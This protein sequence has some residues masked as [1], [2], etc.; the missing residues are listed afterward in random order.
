MQPIQFT[1]IIVSLLLIGCTSVELNEKTVPQSKQSEL[2]TLVSV[3][4]IT[5]TN[6]ASKAEADDQ[7][8]ICY[9]ITDDESEHTPIDTGVLRE[10]P[11]DV[12]SHKLFVQRLRAS[13]LWNKVSYSTPSKRDFLLKSINGML[14]VSGIG[15][16]LDQIHRIHYNSLD[17]R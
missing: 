11:I 15:Y 10:A 4:A 9:D 2:A 8:V 1:L 7:P 3:P 13:P 17:K 14:A 6:D 16:K 12:T 5:S